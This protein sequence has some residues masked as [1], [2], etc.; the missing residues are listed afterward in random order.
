MI[1][2]YA[3]VYC[4]TVPLDDLSRVLNMNMFAEFCL[5]VILSA[6]LPLIHVIGVNQVLGSLINYTQR[7]I[8]N[9]Q[10]VVGDRTDVEY[11][12]VTLWLQSFAR[13]SE[14]AHC[15]ICLQG[16]SNGPSGIRTYMYSLSVP[17]NHEPV[18]WFSENGGKMST[19]M[20]SGIHMTK[21]HW[22]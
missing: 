9:R 16:R 8:L 19:M 12:L 21:D 10:I 13:V 11:K 20:W 14:Y 6:S 7:R 22:Q 15:Q 2:R 5:L 3:F 4:I 18:S 1:E 17:S